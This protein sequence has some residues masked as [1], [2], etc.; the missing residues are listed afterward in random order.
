VKVTFDAKGACQMSTIKHI[1]AG[2]FIAVVLAAAGCA[3]ESSV[4]SFQESSTVTQTATGSPRPLP[5]GPQDEPVLPD[6]GDS[7]ADGPVTSRPAPESEPSAYDRVDDD[8][9]TMITR[10]ADWQAPPFLTVGQTE[11]IVL[12]IGDAQAFRAMIESAVPTVQPRAPIPVT[13]GTD[14]RGTLS[15]NAS[16]AT[17]TPLESQNWSIGEDTRVYFS[18]QVKPL[19]AGELNISAYIESTV[20]GDRVST[21]V[22]PLRIPVHPAAV[23]ARG[24]GDRLSQ[25]SELVKD[26]WLQITTAIGGLAAAGRFGW[27]RYRRQPPSGQDSVATGQRPGALIADQDRGELLP[28]PAV[29][30]HDG[31]TLRSLEPALPPVQ[32]GDEYR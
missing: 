2:L 1:G 13:I 24:W 11:N 20:S 5:P 23:Q 19:A 32:G 8:L 14:V 9:Q 28:A 3:S 7:D 6:A 21:Q 29:G 4:S 30:E 22:V 27:R 25:W 26:Y 15:A 18:W 17:I 12:T 31:V 10:N 16:D